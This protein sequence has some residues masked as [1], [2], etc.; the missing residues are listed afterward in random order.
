[1]LQKGIITFNPTYLIKVTYISSILNFLNTESLAV[2]VSNTRFN[3]QS[4][5]LWTQLVIGHQVPITLVISISKPWT[6]ASYSI[7]SILSPKPMFLKL[8]A[9]MHNGPL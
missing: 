1:M 7:Q 2:Q 4:L 8:W 6:F 3:V 9:G 5:H